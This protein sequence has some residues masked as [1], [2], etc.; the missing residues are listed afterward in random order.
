MYATPSDIRRRKG[1][2]GQTIVE[3]AL[4]VTLL[5]A[6]LFGIVEFG[7]LWFY[8]NHLNNSVR[9]AARYAAVLGSTPAG[10]SGATVDTYL[11]NEISK[12]K[13]N[14]GRIMDPAQIQNIAV[15]ITAPDGSHPASPARG[16]TIEV[17]VR[18]RFMLLSGL[19][20]KYIGLPPSITLKRSASM[21]YEG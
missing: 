19:L 7:R 8:S 14:G 6:I 11:R 13:N 3:F 17:T 9:A 5:L 15:T 1:E 18:Y 16:D 4:V 21:R 2:A 10:F 20:I 12:Q